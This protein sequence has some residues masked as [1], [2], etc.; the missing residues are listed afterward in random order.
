[1]QLAVHSLAHAT[2]A[3]RRAAK[4]AE[5]A[6]LLKHL[7][8]LLGND[9]A[10]AQR[11]ITHLTPSIPPQMSTEDCLTLAEREREFTYSI[12]R[13]E[14]VIQSQDD[15]KGKGKAEYVKELKG[16]KEARRA[17]G[18]RNTVRVNGLREGI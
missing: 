12:L 8:S 7:E 14:S 5:T 11:L 17:Y 3:F 18:R 2:A 9:N 1:M 10:E 13:L 6:T 15:G 16:L 4:P